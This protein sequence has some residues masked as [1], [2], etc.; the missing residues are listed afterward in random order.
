VT[1]YRQH[2]GFIVEASYHTEQEETRFFM[3]AGDTWRFAAFDTIEFSRRFAPLRMIWHGVAAGRSAQN[4]RLVILVRPS[5]HCL[6][7][8]LHRWRAANCW[9]TFLRDSNHE[10]SRFVEWHGI[11]FIHVGMQEAAAFGRSQRLFEQHGGDTLVLARFMQI[12][13]HL[14]AGV[15]G[16]IITSTHSF[17]PSFVGPNLI[18]RPISAV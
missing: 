3:A 6:D 13:R 18:T 1:G 4:K 14:C 9:W 12:L 10:D 5:D 17:L 11:P 2:G 15:T 7:D 16:R 8:L